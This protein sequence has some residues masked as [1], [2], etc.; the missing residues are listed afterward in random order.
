LTSLGG[1]EGRGSVFCTVMEVKGACSHSFSWDAQGHATAN[2]DC[3]LV[4]KP[5]SLYMM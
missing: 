4:K 3:L 1:G 2:C 5:F